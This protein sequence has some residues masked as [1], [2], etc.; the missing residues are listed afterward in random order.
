MSSEGW[1]GPGVVTIA[2]LIPLAREVG[3]RLSITYMTYETP[4]VCFLLSVVHSRL[5]YD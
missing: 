1:Q 4:L 3:E 5:F 2:L